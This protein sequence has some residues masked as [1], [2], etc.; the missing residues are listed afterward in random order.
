MIICYLKFSLARSKAD[1]RDSFTTDP[2]EAEE[3]LRNMEKVLDRIECTSKQKLRY[4][5]SLLGKDTL[6]WW[7]TVSGNKNRPITLNWNDFLKEFAD[8]YTPP[9]YKYCKNVEFL[10]LKTNKLSVAG[11]ELAFVRLSRY[12]PEEVSSDELKRDKFERGL[13]LEI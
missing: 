6:D 5:M 8:K 2:T 9:V 7:E 4:A 3:W 10:K 11:Y 12:A 13:R 1:P